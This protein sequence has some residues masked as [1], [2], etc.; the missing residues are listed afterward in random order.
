M[1]VDSSNSNEHRTSLNFGTSSKF[2]M[3]PRRITEASINLDFSNYNL[4]LQFK[5]DDNT[6]QL[7]VSTPFMYKTANPLTCLGVDCGCCSRKPLS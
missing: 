5:D 1:E 3:A 4:A 6:Y 7:N 2:G